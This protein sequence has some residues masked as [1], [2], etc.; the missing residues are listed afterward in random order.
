MSWFYYWKPYDPEWRAKVR[1]A[2]DVM[3]KLAR[4]SPE[5]SAALIQRTERSL[6][7]ATPSDVRMAYWCLVSEGTLVRTPY[8]VYR[9]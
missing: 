2:M 6:R 3:L 5:S 7:R 1:R 8:G 4:T 9:K